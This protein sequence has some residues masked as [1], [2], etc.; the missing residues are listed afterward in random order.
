MH[1]LIT[2]QLVKKLIVSQFPNGNTSLLSLSTMEEMTTEHSGSA[3][4]C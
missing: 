3:T 4:Q 2:E 1:E